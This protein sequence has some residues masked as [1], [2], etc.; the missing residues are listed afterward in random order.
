[1]LLDG[2]DMR[3][4]NLQALRRVV[5]VVSPKPFLFTASIHENIATFGSQ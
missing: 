4:H 2:K 5:A 3:N 1:V